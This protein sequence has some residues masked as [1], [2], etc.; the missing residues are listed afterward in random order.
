MITN[1]ELTSILNVCIDFTNEKDKNLLM[2]KLLDVAME[3][4]DCDAG[5]IYLKHDDA[6]EF[7]VMKAKSIGID[8]GAHGEKIE[9]PPVPL[10]ESN[11]CAYSAIHHK[12]VNIKDVYAE[13][14]F[15]FTG[16]KRYDAMTGYHT[17]SMLVIPI[18]NDDGRLVGVM[19][20]INGGISDNTNCFLEDDEF[21]LKAL[22]SMTTVLLLN[23]IYT[24]DIKKM[25][26]SFVSAFAAAVDKR[27]PYNGLHTRKVAL[28]SKLIA[29]ELDTLCA[30]EDEDYFD[31]HRI[32]QLVLAAY[33]HDIGKMIIPLGVMNKE[34]RLN[35]GL[36]EIRRRFDYISVSLERDMLKG[37][38][39]KTEYESKLS[40]LDECYSFIESIDKA[41]FLTDDNAARVDEIAG[42]SYTEPS[43]SVLHYLTDEEHEDLKIRKGT[44]TDEE[45][46]VM[47]SH[48]TMTR[49]ILSEVYFNE[50]YANVPVFAASHHELLDG[51]GYPNHLKDKEI[52]LETRILAAADIFDALTAVDRP[53][54]KSMSRQQAF[55]VLDSMADDGKLDGRIVSLLKTA[56]SR[57][58]EDELES[59]LTEL[60]MKMY[61]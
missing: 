47:E 20:L 23:M 18:E 10:N 4:T 40:Q 5:T 38:I 9:L 61:E 55:T 49:D 19:Q 21:V 39:A 14:K 58:T 7:T 44:L 41:G 13:N 3:F 32:E 50:D 31:E 25:M 8:K 17:R 52:G 46:K 29:N 37:T 56:V 26:H 48:V 1:T 36:T 54:K 22:A 60:N 57:Y 35:G 42:M 2:S 51:S 33:L 59:M 43:G 27:T 53:Y 30:A 28:Y 24:A 6:L 16:P 45:R 15:D 11:I 34:T 12:L